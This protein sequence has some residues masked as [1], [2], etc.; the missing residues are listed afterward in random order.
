MQLFIDVEIVAAMSNPLSSALP[1]VDIAPDD[2]EAEEAERDVN[3]QP[4][5]PEAELLVAV[6][7]ESYR[8]VVVSFAPVAPLPHDDTYAVSHEDGQ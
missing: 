2:E 7:R 8:R 3:Q 6:E 5:M 1:A 4:K